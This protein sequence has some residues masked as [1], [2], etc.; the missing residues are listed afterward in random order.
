MTIWVANTSPLVFLGHLGRLQLLRRE[1]RQVCLPLA[2]LAE[3]REKPDADCR[4]VEDACQAWLEVRE[5]R[6]RSAVEI[7]EADLHLGE[8]EAIV[9]ARELGAERLVMDDQ[10]A[11]RFALR[12]RIPVIGTVGILLAARLR[13]EVPSLREELRKLMDLGFRIEPKLVE[14][15][16]KKAGE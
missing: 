16:L 6:D 12:R 4:A 2:V 15:A 11:R 5:V 8:A 3:I 10:D 1:A 13:S 7:I 14:A 9:L